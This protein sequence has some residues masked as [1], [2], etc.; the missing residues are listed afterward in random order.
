MTCTAE[1]RAFRDGRAPE[2][3]YAPGIEKR[4][5]AQARHGDAKQR[6]EIERAKRNPVSAPKDV[7]N[8]V[9]RDGQIDPLI[10]STFFEEARA[11]VSIHLARGHW[12][13]A[14]EAIDAIA[15]EWEL[16]KQAPPSDHAEKLHWHVTQ[17]F[18]TRTANMLEQMGA[19]TVGALLER[20]PGHFIKYKPHGC[21][22]VTIQRIARTL[23]RIGVIDEQEALRRIEEYELG[24]G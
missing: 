20:L 12:E 8:I 15:A 19:A 24:M 17:I 1:Q 14:K 6:A 13:K 2:P 10:E 21:G 4:M 23:V 16:R 7:K 9:T 22:T 11:R 5:A 3:G 18:E